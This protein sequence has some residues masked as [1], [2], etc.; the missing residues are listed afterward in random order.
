MVSSSP[1]ATVV[2]EEPYEL[3]W[4]EWLAGSTGCA[5][6]WSMVST[7]VV[8]VLVE[9]LRKVEKKD[10][11]KTEKKEEKSKPGRREVGERN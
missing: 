2:V 4:V 3:E 5:I 6:L 8:W 7:L 9:V 1:P 11:R 10:L